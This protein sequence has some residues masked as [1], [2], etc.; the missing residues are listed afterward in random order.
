[1]GEAPCGAEMSQGLMCLAEHVERMNVRSAHD[2]RNNKEWGDRIRWCDGTIG[3][4]SYGQAQWSD[5][6]AMLIL[7]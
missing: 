5:D 2:P 7:G 3:M 4:V 6:V 1:M